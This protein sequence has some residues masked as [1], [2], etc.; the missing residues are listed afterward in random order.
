MPGKPPERRSRL[1]S[2]AA[3]APPRAAIRAAGEAESSALLW[4]KA[5]VGIALLPVCYVVT[6]TFLGAFGETS[7][8]GASG[9]L[10]NA[11]LWFFAV[12]VA[13]WLISFFGL[14]R[15][16]Y[17]YV[18]GHEL[19]HA[20]FVL[21]CGGKITAFKVRPEGGHIVSNRNNILISLS[22]Y[23]VPFYS[24]LI[25]LGFGIAGM[26]TDLSAYY[27]N[28]L[29]WG[30]IGFSPAWLMYIAVGATWCFHLTFT[31]WM[32]LKNQPDL[33]Q[34]GTFFS[35]VV[36]YL[37]NLLVLSTMLV[38]VSRQVGLHGFLSDLIGNGEALIGRLF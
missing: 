35:L 12:G 29:F 38:F 2:T 15:P 11:P 23:F 14:P 1:R 18:L 8:G 13:L 26:L 21:L 33:R 16:L 10:G 24:T 28:S 5:L 6:Q 9:I 32:I 31:A 37:V 3:A 19:T 22:P 4:F 7:G 25:V 17:L 27:P 34:N 30:H 36:I 20:F